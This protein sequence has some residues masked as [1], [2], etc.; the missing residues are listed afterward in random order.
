M[1]QKVRDIGEDA[2][3]SRLIQGQKDRHDVIA[4]PGDDCA[5]IDLGP[6]SGEWQLLKT[7]CVIESVHFLTGTEPEKIGWKAMCR[8]ISDIAAMGGMPEHALVTIAVGEDCK[9]SEVEG[10]YRGMRKAAEKFGDVGIVGGET[11]SLPGSGAVISIAMTGT[12]EPAKCAMRSG[13]RVGDVIAVTG[14]LGNS[15]ASGRHLE[16]TPRLHEA[17]WLMD[18]DSAMKPTAMMDLSD[19]L[20]KDLPRLAEMSAISGYEID[21]SA[22][23]VNPD[24][25]LAAAVGEGEDYELL[26]TIPAAGAENLRL[27]WEEQFPNCPLSYIGQMTDSGDRTALS[28]GW[29]HFGR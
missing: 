25:D 23:P 10:W 1:D 3:I 27:A 7:D 20:A 16:F 17:R 14:G 21:L 13:A 15:F 12:V 19:G 8:V 5:V 26:F 24:S 28:G 6:A 11:A 9:V 2:L 22:I 4:G 18:R 29:E